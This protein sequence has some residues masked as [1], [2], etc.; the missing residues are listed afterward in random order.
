MKLWTT[1]ASSY[2]FRGSSTGRNRCLLYAPQSGEDTRRYLNKKAKK[3]RAAIADVSRDAS[4][5]PQSSMSRAA[6]WRT[7]PLICSSAAV[8]SSKDSRG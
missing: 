8:A 2:G 7:T 1:P 6:R 5:R 3:G 4:K